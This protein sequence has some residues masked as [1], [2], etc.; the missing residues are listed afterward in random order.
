MAVHL[1][2][3]ED[4]RL[5][6]ERELDGLEA[7]E[8]VMMLA[9][10]ARAREAFLAVAHEKKEFYLQWMDK[11]HK[12]WLKNRRHHIKTYKRLMN[13]ELCQVERR[14]LWAE[15]EHRNHRSDGIRGVA[16][17][18]YNLLRLGVGA[19]KQKS[20]KGPPTKED[21]ITFLNRLRATERDGLE[22]KR[23]EA[24]DM[25]AELK[26]KAKLKKAAVREQAIR[27]RKVRG[28][29]LPMPSSEPRE[30]WCLPPVVVLAN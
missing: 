2:P 18:E 16:W 10:V 1:K 11:G 28:W 30:P 21:A 14:R 20:E 29:C 4:R 12:D 9:A 6:R 3:F 24:M 17:F 13:Y 27:R 19:S 7:N 22:K 15:K 26:E 23:E 5:K 25:M 8:H